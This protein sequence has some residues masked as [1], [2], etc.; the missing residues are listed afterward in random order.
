[1]D[2]NTPCVE[3]SADLADLVPR[4]LSNRQADLA[5]AHQL[6]EKGDFYMLAAMAHRIRGSASSYGFSGLGEIARAIE[7]AA[8]HGDTDALVVE[9]KAFET[10]LQAVQVAYV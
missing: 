6:L 2:N 5:F 7:T 4:Y 9:L 10:F 8:E 1:M 3:V